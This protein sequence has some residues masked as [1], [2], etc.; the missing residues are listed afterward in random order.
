[1]EELIDVTARCALQAYL[2]HVLAVAGRGA[3]GPLRFRLWSDYAEGL[4]E[5]ELALRHGCSPSKVRRLLAIEDHATAIAGAV[6]EVL[7]LH[8]AFRSAARSQP[9]TQGITEVLCNHLV[10]DE[11]EAGAVTLRRWLRQHL[12]A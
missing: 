9:L 10:S 8:P 2:P 5:P 1:M 7:K 3:E 12:S 6:A 4:S 11:E